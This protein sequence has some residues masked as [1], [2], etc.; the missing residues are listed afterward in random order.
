VRRIE[1]KG[2]VERC[3]LKLFGYFPWRCASCRGKF[4]IKRRSRD[5]N[6]PKEYVG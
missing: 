2:I 1:R 3:F 4:F 6:K 5:N